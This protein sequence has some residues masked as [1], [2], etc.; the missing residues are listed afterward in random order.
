MDDFGNSLSYWY[1]WDE[2][3]HRFPLPDGFNYTGLLFCTDVPN[4]SQKNFGIFNGYE[5]IFHKR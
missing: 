4:G 3:L 5:H 1:T 2:K